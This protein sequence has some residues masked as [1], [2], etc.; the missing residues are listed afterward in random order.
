MRCN[1]SREF[2]KSVHSKTRSMT[3]IDGKPFELAEI[4]LSKVFT[5]PF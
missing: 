5:D 2:R 4:D 3:K 1:K